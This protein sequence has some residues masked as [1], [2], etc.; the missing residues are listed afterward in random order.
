MGFGKGKDRIGMTSGNIF[1]APSIPTQEGQE[2]VRRES[3]ETLKQKDRD[4]L[5]LLKK[6]SK[7]KKYTMFDHSACY[8]KMDRFGQARWHICGGTRSTDGA[9]SEKCLHCRFFF[10]V[11][12]FK[13]EV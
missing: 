1:Y 7:E 3:Y 10:P 11:P 12:T 5:D 2:R 8:T 4:L 6:G 13:E 9:L